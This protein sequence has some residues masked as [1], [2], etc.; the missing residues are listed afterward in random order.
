[1]KSKIDQEIG[2]KNLSLADPMSK[3]RNT[4]LS[5]RVTTTQEFPDIQTIRNAIPSHCF[6]PST[7]V[8]MGYVL[9][10][11]T[12]AAVLGWAALTYIPQIPN[13]LLRGVAWM[14]YGYAQGLVCTGIW[15]LA[16]EAGHGAFSVH[17][18]FNDFVGWVLH[19]SL[20]VPYF[21]W[22]F[23]HHR[24]HRFTGHMEKDMAFVPQTKDAQG[25]PGLKT[26]YLDPEMFEDA[27]IVQLVQLLGHQLFG[28][29]LYLFFN[30]SAGVKS[31]QREEPNWW[32]M[33]HFEPRSAVFRLNEAV[34]IA[35]SDLGIGLTL[36]A[37]YFASTAIGWPAVFLLYIV[38]YFWVHHWLVAITYLHHTHPDVHHYTP[39]GWTFVKGALATV[40]RDFGWVGRSLF[41]GIIDTHV[42]HHLFP[43]IPFYKAEEATEAIKPLLGDLYHCEQSSFIGQLWSTF[44]TCRYVEDDPKV[45]GAMRW[46]E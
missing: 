7:W 16:H 6:Q 30:V 10:D 14:A 38:P 36:T 11:V 4:E 23:S 45:P 18:R 8:S 27:P 22:K 34:Y 31:K 25:R 35:L 41:H 37:L 43:R 42:V 32:R 28:W 20:L 19:S 9:R 3:H 21:S 40:D 44:T 15:I 46:V 5:S 17:R 39:E 33:S 13:A 26:L 12:M 2:K 29:Q 24:H 1:M